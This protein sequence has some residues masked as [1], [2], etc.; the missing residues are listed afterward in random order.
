MLSAVIIDDE[1]DSIQAIESTINLTGSDIQVIGKGKTVQEGIDILNSTNPDVVF[2]DVKLGNELS[3]S[4][5]KH[6]TDI[7]FQ[8]IF[9]SAYDEYA[10][11]AFKYS[12][13]DFLLK[14]ID[15]D[16]FENAIHKVNEKIASGSLVYNQLRNLIY[17]IKAPRPF[18]LSVPTSDG[19]EFINIDDLFEIKAEGSYSIL[20]FKSNKNM[21][22]SRNIGEFQMQLP[23]EDFC[24]VHNSYLINL[25][26]VKKIRRKGGL[27]AE[28][29]NGKLIPIS[30]NK[31]DQFM[32]KIDNYIIQK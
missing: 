11:K 5:F 21:M 15:P 25:R 17:N 14:P 31:K 19:V 10:I 23:E 32:Q 4:I 18:M 2:F 12:A 16:E 1:V 20:S 26:H 30:R 28:M 6:I 8:V 13:I 29:Q 3:F 7:N 27:T 9:I 24:R 22:V